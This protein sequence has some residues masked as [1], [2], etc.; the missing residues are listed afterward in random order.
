MF[1]FSLSKNTISDFTKRKHLSEENS[2]EI[3]NNSKDSEINGYSSNDDNDMSSEN[4]SRPIS[5]KSKE[6]VC[7]NDEE[8]E[9]DI[10]HS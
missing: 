3:V 8:T 10:Q 5:F 9:S 1:F 6:S 2:E 7:S 4:I